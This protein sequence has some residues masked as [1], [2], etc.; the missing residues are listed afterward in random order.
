MYAKD[1]NSLFYRLQQEKKKKKKL[2]NLY[3]CMY[4][5]VCNFPRKTILMWSLL[6]SCKRDCKVPS[7]SPEYS[8]GLK[9]QK[10]NINSE[11]S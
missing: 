11:F 6:N 9:D 7:N 8:N 2:S 5:N 1:D 4:K 3:A 10:D